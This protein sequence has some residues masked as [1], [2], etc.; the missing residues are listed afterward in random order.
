MDRVEFFFMSDISFAL[1]N[2]IPAYVGI[3]CNSNFIGRFQKNDHSAGKSSNLNLPI[4]IF[5]QFILLGTLYLPLGRD[6]FTLIFDEMK[7]S[8]EY[9]PPR[10]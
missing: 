5:L 3:Y 4:G 6:P 9:P 7:L 8:G 10:L 1:E 2:G